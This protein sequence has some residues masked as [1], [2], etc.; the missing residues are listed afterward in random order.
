MVTQEFYKN[1]AIKEVWVATRAVID[2]QIISQ[3]VN[4]YPVVARLDNFRL[5][6]KKIK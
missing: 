3:V 6:F 4:R 1:V 2:T 5:W